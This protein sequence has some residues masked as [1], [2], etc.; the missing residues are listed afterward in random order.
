MAIVLSLALLV[1]ATAASPRAPKSAVKAQRLVRRSTIE[2]LGQYKRG[3]AKQVCSLMTRK[4]RKSLGGD[5]SCIVMV[6]F[7][8]TAYPIGRVTIKKVSFRLRHAWANVSGYLNGSR[9]RRLA[10]VFKWEQGRY[11]LDRSLTDYSHLFG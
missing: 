10:A 2:I 5:K 1:P 8:S 9:S 3:H 11:R 6:K 4:A 7:A